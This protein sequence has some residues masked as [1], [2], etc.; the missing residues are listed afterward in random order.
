M[1]TVTEGLRDVIAGS[2][3]VCYLDGVEGV[4]AYGGYNIHELAEHATFE[5]T[6][7]LLW[8]GRLPN[9]SELDE[10]RAKL[11]SMRAIPQ[12][13]VEQ[14][15][16]YPKDAVPM[17]SLRTAVSALADFD[18]EADVHTPEAN[19]MKAHRLTAQMATIVAALDRVRNGK[20][21]I[22][23][24]ARLSHA[25][26][27]LYM[28]SGEEPD[29]ME[30]RV[31]DI[32]LI[33]HADHEYNASTFACRVIAGTLA[34]MY[35]AVVGG[36]GALKG[37]LH[38]GANEGVMRMLEEITDP[39]QTEEYV[40][41]KLARKEKIMGF[42]H[43]VYRTEDPRATHLR[44]MS[45]A[46][47]DKTGHPELYETSSTIE[48]IMNTEKKIN[49]NVDFYSATTYHALSIPTDLF[50]PIFAVSRVSGWTAHVLEQYANNKLIRPRC[51][52]T[53]PQP[54]QPWAP[55]EER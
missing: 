8:F 31:F 50:T 20:E 9:K 40:R 17:A 43:A 19:L 22:A 5:E 28:L 35:S 27:F 41:G 2:S 32:A 12:E 13:L 18:P 49:A 11:A 42:G 53:G 36:I 26:N 33:L 51:E 34:D 21:P 16:L 38:G 37:P 14:M 39:S 4:L 44:K 15:K 6:V 25:A 3:R 48:R 30:S 1:A 10:F 55:I 45:K 54:D 24:N 52:Y 47:C 23:P 29:E 7:Y 46:L